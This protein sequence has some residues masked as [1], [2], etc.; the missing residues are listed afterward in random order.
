[1]YLVPKLYVS[2]C[3]LI[4]LP[5]PYLVCTVSSGLA[6]LS[7]L[8]APQPLRPQHLP[9]ICCHWS[10]LCPKASR[11]TRKTPTLNQRPG[12]Q[13]VLSEHV[14]SWQALTMVMRPQKANWIIHCHTVG[15]GWPWCQSQ[16]LEKQV[17]ADH[18]VPCLLGSHMEMFD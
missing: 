13:Q 17:Q 14:L 15:R 18:R 11:R 5:V 4:E 10:V 2:L 6:F 8:S 1:M 9:V 3:H 12:T 7:Y 16:D